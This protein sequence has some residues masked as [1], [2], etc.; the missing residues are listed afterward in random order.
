MSEVSTK[1][2]VM[3]RMKTSWV[4]NK[5]KVVGDSFVPGSRIIGNFWIGQRCAMWERFQMVY[6]SVVQYIAQTREICLK[7]FLSLKK[8]D[9]IQQTHSSRLS[10]VRENLYIPLS[11]S[12][13]HNEKS[14][15]ISS[16]LFVLKSSIFGAKLPPV[17]LFGGSSLMSEKKILHAE[18]FPS[19]T[20]IHAV[21]LS[22]MMIRE[23]DSLPQ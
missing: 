8:K 19:S 22:T 4:L 18:S 13:M 6:I 7:L 1:P 15:F 2:K 12:L 17:L 21:M 3:T 11:I 10:S 5:R 16:F 20:L 9:N 23:V 14:L